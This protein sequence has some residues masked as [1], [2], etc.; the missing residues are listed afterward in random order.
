[1]AACLEAVRTSK[2]PDMVSALSAMEPGNEEL[3]FASVVLSK[4]LDFKDKVGDEESW[5]CCPGSPV[6]GVLSLGSC[7]GSPVL[8]VLS[9]ESC[10]GRP[11]LGVLS[12]EPC[13]GSPVLGVF[14]WESCPGGE[15]WRGVL[16]W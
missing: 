16:G 1:M 4:T 3:A 15:S 2:D 5:G 12:R 9:W 8:G 11:F 13:L 14:S 6:L 10:P 7:P